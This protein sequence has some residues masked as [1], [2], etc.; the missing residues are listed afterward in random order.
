MIKINLLP[1][2]KVKKA[3]RKVEIQSQLILASILLSVLFLTLG[4][5]WILLNEKVDGL[6]TEKTKLTAELESLKAKVKQVENYEKDKKAVEEKIRIIQQLRKNQSVPVF[7]LDQISRSLPER[8][9]L[10]NLTE[11]N[12]VIDL[13]G[14]AT[15]NSEIVDFINNLKKSA[16]FKDVQI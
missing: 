6:G 14:K 9:W 5:A 15:T 12:G 11:Q 8:V 7:L 2:Q 10:M 3:K 1:S 16:L 13:E 4:Y